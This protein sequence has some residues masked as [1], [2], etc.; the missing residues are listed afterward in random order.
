MSKANISLSEYDEEE[1]IY[2]CCECDTILDAFRD[3][4]IDKNFRCNNC[5]WEDKEGNDSN[6]IIRP[7]YRENNNGKDEE[8]ENRY[9]VCDNCD[10]TIDCWNSNIYCLYKGEDKSPTEEITVCQTCNDELIEEFK[11]EGYNCDDWEDEED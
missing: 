5:Y 4:A 7:D 6:N 9:V 11:E 2:K 10:D 8:S 3:G 1:E